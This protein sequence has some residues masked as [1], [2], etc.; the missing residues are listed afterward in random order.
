[1]R[2]TISPPLLGIAVLIISIQKMTSRLTDYFCYFPVSPEMRRWGLGVTASGFTRVPPGS[3]YPP[4]PHPEDHRLDWAHGRVLD[5]VQIVLISAG[6]GWL[7]TSHCKPRRVETGMVFLLLPR[8]WHRYRPDP[9]TGWEESWIEVQG[10]VVNELLKARTFPEGAILRTGAVEAGLDEV[11]ESIH[12]QARK[13]ANGFNPEFSAAA[14]R[15]LAICER[16]GSTDAISSRVQRAVRDAERYLAGHAGEPVNLEALAA[17]LGVAYSHFRRAFRAK[18][19]YAPWQ[20]VI[21][22]RLVRAR[23]LLASSDAKLDEIAGRVGFSSGFHLSTAFKQAYG[24]SPS[25][26]RKSVR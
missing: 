15:A 12:C 20:Y 21:H 3:P 8:L 10:P 4:K 25:H 11:L 1:M 16:L 2:N 17:R 14:L 7:E 5:A 24:L 22:L 18:T 9:G 6:G 13:G 19:G 23:R 26:W